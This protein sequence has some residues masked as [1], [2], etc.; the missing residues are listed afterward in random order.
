MS[1][2]NF[3]LILKSFLPIIL[4]SDSV[5]IFTENPGSMIKNKNGIVNSAWQIKNHK[6]YTDETTHFQ[7][8]RRTER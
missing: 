2:K 1:Y 3:Q 5:I 6:N 8:Q 4:S 7:K